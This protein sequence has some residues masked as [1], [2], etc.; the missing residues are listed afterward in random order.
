MPAIAPEMTRAVQRLPDE[1]AR[2]VADPKAY[3][4]LDALHEQL[5]IVRRDYPFA[6]SQL[7][8]YAPFW[9]ASKFDDIQ[10]IARQNDV[11]LSGMGALT[12]L[13]M[14]SKEIGRAHV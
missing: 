1:L 8:D 12:T 13:E 5:K 14:A 7:P 11:F 6:R 3:A 2:A 9:V 4:D 10:A